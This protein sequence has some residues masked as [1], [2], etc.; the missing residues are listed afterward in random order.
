MLK[1]LVQMGG[2]L[3]T[4]IKVCRKYICTYTNKKHVTGVVLSSITLPKGTGSCCEVATAV[5]D[6]PQ[7]RLETRVR[8]FAQ[9]LSK[10]GGIA[11]PR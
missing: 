9:N 10:S 2:H 7:M 11:L 8:R 6:F 4:L 5:R 3:N 1:N